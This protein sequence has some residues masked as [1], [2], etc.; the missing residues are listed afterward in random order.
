MKDPNLDF[1]ESFTIG[2]NT[3]RSTVDEDLFIDQ[4]NLA[5]AYAFHPKKFA[6]YSTGY[7]LAVNHEAKLKVELERTYARM[8]EIARRM[9]ADS[10]KK[11]TETMVESVVI[12]SEDYRF[13][14]DAYLEAQKQTGLLRAAR[15][16]MIHRKDMLVSLGANYR[17]EIHADTSLRIDQIKNK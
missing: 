16:A 10:G 1:I 9:L 4:T 15:D 3:Y 17:A 14:Q 12:T 13:I 7:E 2:K 8:D 6:F 11:F 5:D